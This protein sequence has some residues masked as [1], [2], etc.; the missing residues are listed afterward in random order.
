MGG[1]LPP[2]FNIHS[3]IDI[4]KKL[5]YK[6]SM[7]Q[8]KDDRLITDDLIIKAFFTKSGRLNGNYTP[9]RY[10][11]VNYPNILNYLKTR[12]KDSESIR[13]TL[14]RIYMHIEERPKCPI[15]GKPVGYRG[16]RNH[17]FADTCLDPNCYYKLLL[18]RGKETNLKL[19][20]VPNSGGT[21]EA[22]EK[23]KSTCLKRYGKEWYTQTKEYVE[24]TTKTNIEKYG[25]AWSGAALEVIEKRRQTTIKKYGGMGFASKDIQEKYENTC[26]EK[27]GVKNGGGSKEA[28]MKIYQTKTKNN[29]WNT[30]QLEED[31]YELLI[32][33][34]DKDNIIRQYRDPRYMNP[35]TNRYWQCDFYIKS[36]D[37]FI[38][39]QGI[40]T[41]GSHPFDDTN[42]K[43]L[44]ILEKWK[45]ELEKG[46][47][48][49]SKAIFGWTKLDVLKRKIA[50]END[51]KFIEIFGRSLDKEQ[52]INKLHNFLN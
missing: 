20:G 51:L 1:K 29:T 16:K 40:W 8:I 25:V 47:K 22:K 23:I 26:I 32:D 48:M 21:P 4:L 14:L 31:Y 46:H 28:Q 44:E 5:K 50:K 13:E 9:E 7:L 35:K 41:H 15:C 18:E 11:S 30:S 37:I 3:L 19:Y 42:Q 10:L 24:V 38:E 17:L 12:F 6:I 49:Y 27:F 43:D 34:F 2:I 33:L 39:I 45:S 36:K 52:L